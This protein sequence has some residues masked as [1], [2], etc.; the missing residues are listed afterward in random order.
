DVARIAAPHLARHNL[1]LRLL[2]RLD[3]PIMVMADAMRDALLNL[4]INSTESGQEEGEIEL[5]AWQEADRLIFAIRDRG[6]GLPADTDVFAPFV[7]TKETGHGL[8]LA[9]SRRTVE[10]HGGSIR[11]EDRD[12]GGATLT[13][14]LPQPPTGAPW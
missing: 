1:R 5:E 8:G 4:V 13:I 2:C 6:S 11:A 10:A 14:I 12:G 3:G 9:I 7:T